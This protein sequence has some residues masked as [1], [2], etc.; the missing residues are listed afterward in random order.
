MK[1]VYKLSKHNKLRVVKLYQWLLKF[2]ESKVYLKEF[3]EINNLN[4]TDMNNF[5]Y[6]YDF[7]RKNKPGYMEKINPIIEEYR[8]TRQPLGSLALKYGIDKKEIA[9]YARHLNY[10][11]TIEEYKS[12]QLPKEISMDFVKVKSN[13]QEIASVEIKNEPEFVEKQ[14]D[15]EIII[16]KGIKVCISPAIEPLNV[17][18]IIELLR[19]I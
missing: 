14:N 6:I 1:R 11:N 5:K 18:K 19:T 9:I 3:C 16:S 8:I 13:T 17:I 12:G 2:K 7:S 4:F 15:L 10:L